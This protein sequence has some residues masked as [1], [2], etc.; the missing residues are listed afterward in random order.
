MKTYPDKLITFLEITTIYS[1]SIYPCVAQIVPDATLGNHNS[2]V[3][4]INADHTRIDGGAIK[5]SNLFHSFKDFNVG[6]G[7]SVYFSNPQGIMNILSRITGGNPSQIMGKLGVSGNANLFLVNPNGILFGPNSSLDVKGSFFATTADGIKLGEEG[8]FSATNPESSNL[9]AVNPSALFLNQI[10]AR[11]SYIHNYGNLKS[12]GDLTL[13]SGD[14]KL[15]GE[16]QAAGNLTLQAAHT[17]EIRDSTTQPFI[18]KTGGELKIVSE[19][20]VDIFALHHPSSGLY[21]GSDMTIA[22]GAQV[23]GDA[24]YISGGNFRIQKLDGSSG[25]LRSPHDPVIRSNG[26]VSMGDYQGASL[27][28]LAGG[29]VTLGN[30]TITGRDTTSQSLQETVILSDGTS[31]S[32]NGASQA[33]LDVRAGIA[34]INN[35]AKSADITI[36]DVK[37]PST[38]EGLVFLSNQYSPGGVP[39]NIKVGKIDT[40]VDFFKVSRGGSIFIDSKGQVNVTGAMNTS[41]CGL[42]CIGSGGNVRIVA[43]GNIE[44]GSIDTSSL[45]PEGGNINITSRAGRIYID[46]AAINTLGRTRAGDVILDGAAGIT[47]DNSSILAYISPL[48]ATSNN[49][50]DSSIVLKTG[51]NGDI[52][53]ENGS[54]IASLTLGTKNSPNI[55]IGTPTFILRDSAIAT[56]TVDV[57]NFVPGLPAKSEGNSGD[58]NFNVNGRVDLDKVLAKDKVNLSLSIA[59]Q[60]ISIDLPIGVL[61]L[62]LSEGKAGDININNN[63]A[64][65]LNNGIVVGSLTIAPGK[66]GDVNVN[67]GDLIIRNSS[68]VAATVD[69]KEYGVNSGGGDAGNLTINSNNVEVTGDKPGQ[70]INI[71]LSFNNNAK[72]IIIPFG[73]FAASLKS[74]TAGNLTINT[75]R[76][77][78]VIFKNGV[79]A[80]T[81]TTGDKDAG[82]FNIS[83]GNLVVEDSVVA[84]TTVSIDGKSKGAG[85]NM[86]IDASRSINVI[87]KQENSTVK[88]PPI[89][90]LNRNLPVGLFSQT[91]SSGPAGDMTIKTA[92]LSIQGGGS[93]AA[94]TSGE[95][96]G[97]KLNVDAWNSIEIIGVNPG[98]NIPSIIGSQVSDRGQGNDITIRTSSLIIKNGATISGGVY[99]E[100]KNKGG[101]LTVNADDIYLSGTSPNNKF[102]SSLLT[103]TVSENIGGDAGNLEINT[104]RL[105]LENG[106]IITSATIGAGNGGK[107]TINAT[108]SVS[109]IGTAG[110]S[111]PTSIVTGTAGTGK[112]EDLI[113][114][115]P[116]LTIKNGGLVSTATY[117]V[118]KGNNLIINTNGGRINI[119]GKV[120]NRSLGG[121]LAGSG[122]NE[123]LVK[124]IQPYLEYFE[125]SGTID[126]KKASGDGG[127]V[128]I[129]TGNLL[130]Q[131]GGAISTDTVGVGKAGLMNINADTINLINGGTITGN[132]RGSGKAGDINITSP[133]LT[134]SG[135]ANIAANTSSTGEGGS[136]TITSP[137]N[138]LT[139]TGGEISTTTTSEGKAGSINLEEDEINLNDTRITANTSGFGKAG[140]ITIT[141]PNLNLS[142]GANITA[143][144]DAAGEGGNITITSPTSVSI[145]GGGKISASTS[146]AGAGGQ[147]EINNPRIQ[148][149]GGVNIT[150]STE[151]AGNAGSIG[152]RGEEIYLDGNINANTSGF[153]KAGDITITSPEL[154]LSDRANIAANTNINSSGEGGNITITS[155]TSV[156]IQG[157]GKISAS[158]SG[159]GA[160]GQIEINN[161]RIHMKGGV[162]ITT[163]TE[164]AGNAGSIGL[165]GEEIY[166]DGNIN[167]NTSGQGKAGDITI[168][169][170]ELT[171]SDRANIAANTNINSTGEGG[172]ITIT[173][174]TSVSISGGGKISA[175]TSGAGAG[176]QIEINNPRIHM[177]GGV[178]ITTSTDGAGNAGS[179]GLRGEEIYLDGNIN[180]NTS[181][182]GKAGDIT[183]TSPELTLSDRA[184]IA[185]NT[186]INSTGEG[187]NITIT[188]PGDNLT[189]TGGEIS[190]STSAV[191]IGGN[192]TIKSQNLT[193]N[194]SRLT[195]TSDA[196]GNAGNISLNITNNIGVDNSKISTTSTQADGGN[197]NISAGVITLFNNSDITTNVMAGTGTGGNINLTA[198]SILALTDSDI[199]SFSPEGSGGNITIDTP[200]FIGQNY[201]TSSPKSLSNTLDN[202][203][204]VDVDASGKLSSGNI[205]IPDVSVLRN[206]LLQLP[207]QVIDTSRLLAN[208]CVVRSRQNQGKFIITGAGNLPSRP[209]DLSLS[210][211]STGNIN[212]IPSETGSSQSGKPILEAGGLYKLPDGRLILS[213]ECS[214]S[215]GTEL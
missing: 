205:T 17:I 58:I 131:N 63:P 178:N 200:V 61:T 173:S 100:G 196:S 184:N 76:E 50:N 47:I 122:V 48:F 46:N 174:P 206:G 151:G 5:G 35:S 144:T 95:G 93:V 37:L 13:A 30:V 57:N 87:N 70:G 181:G 90:E 157:G 15:Q 209:T 22:S 94:S 25:G 16:L 127:A 203:A 182:F 52:I 138:N 176:G 113:I 29:A 33:T 147:I 198:N 126:P 215:D 56:A 75:V 18:A 12:G 153:G 3:T 40:F 106:G 214:A 148:M 193:L 4:N 186:N 145:S 110:D 117:G 11:S 208:S 83:T 189:I 204:Q 42:Y 191:G 92:R 79:I 38:E 6:E 133:E 115:T 125:L 109:V 118:S 99:A 199:L 152:L 168:T 159:A 8:F 165:R 68:L 41:A 39:G 21:S 141:S 14:I 82:D 158:T 9:L 59:G 73:L 10:P 167:A 156:S 101:N 43:D 64:V 66:G 146:G 135:G 116:L 112:G 67:S 49:A 78:N 104:K 32:I 28:I 120:P 111:L 213:R 55:N 170:P 103:A 130:I 71:P 34:G 107:L 169:S 140:D 65:S 44:T 143:N 7:K 150:T 62:S 161:P 201:G 179:I 195:A 136:I 45:G 171:L 123:D 139:I 137:G 128:N 155:P 202:N 188:S 177:K 53:V 27:H 51:V 124:I 89:P 19:E 69:G 212:F 142:D 54:V 192:L 211:F 132:T 60:A 180:A 160:G 31:L 175:S 72:P 187:G 81:L 20:K 23:I 88:A 86:N 163:S 114:N 98:E 85:G 121:I 2:A 166:L 97:G 102:W 134:L 108:E 91:E 162:N 96:Q 36:G 119:D 105:T 149:K 164:G 26:D 183:I 194:N 1:L 154:T 197:I 77:G 210:H 74:G 24:R 190:V 207:N 185:A 84:T 129:F 172:N 80:T